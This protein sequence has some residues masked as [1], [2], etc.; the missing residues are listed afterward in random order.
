VAKYI[1]NPTTLAE[2]IVVYIC[3]PSGAVEPAAVIGWLQKV[4]LHIPLH[5]PLHKFT[6]YPSHFLKV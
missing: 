5:T 4:T 6:N 3:M 1:S 2:N